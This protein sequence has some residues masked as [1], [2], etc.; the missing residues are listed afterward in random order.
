MTVLQRQEVGTTDWPGIVRIVRREAFRRACAYVII[1][2]IRA[3]CPQAE[4]SN[5]HAAEVMN[6]ARKELA[7]AG[8]GV[9]FVHHDSKLG[10]EYG[11]GV[12]GPNNLVG[13]CDVL[14]ELRR[15]KDDPTARRMLVSRRYGDQDVTARL[16]GHRYVVTP[17]P[18]EEEPEAEREEGGEGD[19][20]PSS[21]VPAH[22][23][24]TLEAIRRAGPAGIL[25]KD[26]QAIT[27]A[28]FATLS[29]QCRELR[30]LGLIAEAGT[31]SKNDPYRYRLAEQTP[32][33][34][35]PTSDPEYVRYLNSAAWAAKR[36]E[37]L[38]RADGVCEE[39][40]NEPRAGGDRGPP[41]E[42][43]AGGAGAGGGPHR[44]LPRVP[45]TRPPV[46]TAARCRSSTARPRR[47]SWCPPWP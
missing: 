39:C 13:S 43:R 14:I 16:V 47:R 29:R 44:P 24:P 30:E 18:A 6:L 21:K 2:T 40:G 22:L 35:A 9:L 33:R 38:A 17:A 3:W 27:R 1:D 42:L 11:A 46:G 8:L 25:R 4:H 12:A 10:G 37:I 41:P 26:V 5:T 36:A 31:G 20:P 19:A 23:Q 32:A 7:A 45:S 28:T 34:G 15:V